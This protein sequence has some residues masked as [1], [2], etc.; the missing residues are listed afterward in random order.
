MCGGLQPY[1][2]AGGQGS[3]NNHIHH[4]TAKW[5]TAAGTGNH[6]HNNVAAVFN[7]AG[8]NLANNNTVASVCR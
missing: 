8:G 6:V 4:N 2:I 1:S 3:N 7:I 5:I